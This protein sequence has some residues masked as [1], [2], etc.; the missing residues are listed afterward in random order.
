MSVKNI[1][2][3]ILDD[4]KVQESTILEKANKEAEKIIEAKEAEIASMLQNNKT[5][6][7]E[8]GNNK[9]ERLIQNAY[10]QVRNNRLKA[11][12]EVIS[13]VFEKALKSLNTMSEADFIDYFKNTVSSANLKGNGC[14]LI[15]SDMHKHI[16]SINV[17]DFNSNIVDCQIDDS[18]GNGFVIKVDNV[19]YNYT[20]KAVLESL[21]LEL[22]S[23]VNRELF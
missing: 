11:K 17:K 19:Y 22:T 16:A 9:K 23:E 7:I 15:N 3:K 5:K 14:V 18:I 10:L 4:A 12:Q 2:E 1:V 6:A 20:F 13:N 8:E 21:K